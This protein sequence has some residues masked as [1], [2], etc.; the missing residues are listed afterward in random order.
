MVYAHNFNAEDTSGGELFWCDQWSSGSLRNTTSKIRCGPDVAIYAFNL[1]TLKQRQAVSCEFKA[2]QEYIVRYFLGEL[3]G[4]EG[5][6]ELSKTVNV[7]LW[8]HWP[9]QAHQPYH[10]PHPSM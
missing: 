9:P 5:G 1:S 8:T 6:K 10:M 3:E 7:Q 4:E 2:S